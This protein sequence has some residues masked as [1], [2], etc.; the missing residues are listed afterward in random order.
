MTERPNKYCYPN[1]TL[2][3]DHKCLQYKFKTLCNNHQ[4]CRYYDHINKC[5]NIDHDL[6]NTYTNETECKDLC[7]WNEHEQSCNVKKS[8]S[9]IANNIK[10]T[11]PSN[12]LNN[13]D[14]NSNSLDLEKVDTLYMD[15]IIKS[16]VK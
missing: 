10:T 16:M 13:I 5:L 12:T 9:D 1:L 6:C 4:D 8:L 15:Y 14:F 3:K 7:H 11:I 2:D